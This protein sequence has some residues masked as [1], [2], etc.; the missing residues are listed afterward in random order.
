[1]TAQPDSQETPFRLEEATIGDLHA[2]IKSG[3]TTV[4]AVVQQYLD[5]VRAY[6]GVASMLVTEDGLPVPEAPGVV[7]GGATIEFP[8]ETIKASDILPDLDKYQGPPLEFGRMEPT[9]SDPEVAQQFGNRLGVL[10]YSVILDRDGT[11]VL[12][13]AGEID[14]ETIEATIGPLLDGPPVASST[15]G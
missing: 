10:P 12:I 6:N 2:A 7:R 13:H 5:R 14:R 1:M 8:T 9:V 3:Q 11:V 4:V 15:S